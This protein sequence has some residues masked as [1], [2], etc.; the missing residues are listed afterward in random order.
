MLDILLV[1]VTFR[2]IKSFSSAS[3]SPILLLVHCVKC[4]VAEGYILVNKQV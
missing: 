3:I 2:S 1:K 4:F